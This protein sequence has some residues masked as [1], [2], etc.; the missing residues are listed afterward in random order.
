MLV[1]FDEEINKAVSKFLRFHDIGASFPLIIRIVNVRSVK[2]YYKSKPPSDITSLLHRKFQGLVFT[3]HI[4]NK[5]IIDTPA[6]GIAIV[7]PA[8]PDD[9]PAEMI[10]RRRIQGIQDFSA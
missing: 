8:I 1:L 5:E 10:G 2:E 3:I 4:V 6:Y 9:L 7:Q